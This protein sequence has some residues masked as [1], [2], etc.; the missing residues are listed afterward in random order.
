MHPNAWHGFP[1]TAHLL[2]IYIKVINI[3][4]LNKN[5]RCREAENDLRD[6]GV[7]GPRGPE[8][9]APSLT[10]GVNS[11]KPR[12]PRA[13]PGRSD[14]SR[15]ARSPPGSAPGHQSPLRERRIYREPRG[16]L[17]HVTAPPF[18]GKVGVALFLRPL[19]HLCL[20]PGSAQRG[21]HPTCGFNKESANVHLAVKSWSQ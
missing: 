4:S 13:S 17:R 21:E 8:C 5:Y 14:P 15:S 10:P 11:G 3:C 19:R 9:Q 12:P 20:I 7:G 16:V 2:K 6:S 1:Y 18:P